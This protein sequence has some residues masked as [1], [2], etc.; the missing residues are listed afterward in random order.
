M[1]I[2][3]KIIP[4]KGVELDNHELNVD[5]M[6]ATYIKNLVHDLNDNNRISRDEGSNAYVWTP[7]ELTERYCNLEL[8]AGTNYVVGFHYFKEANQGFVFAYNNNNNHF[9]YR[10]K[11]NTG[12][13]EMIVIDPCFNFQ[14][15]PKYF[16]G[17]GR[18]AAQTICRLNKANGQTENVIYLEFTENF[19]D[20]RFLC[21]E[22]V[23]ATHGFN[24]TDF[25]YFNTSD[26]NCNRCTWFNLGVPAPFGCIGVTPVARDTSD[27][28][29]RTRPNVMNY[30]GW[31]FRVQIIDQWNRESEYDIISDTYFTQIG[32]SCLANSSGLPRCVRLRFPAGC[33]LVNQIVL[34][35]RNCAGKT[36]GFST[37]SD[38]YKFTTVNKYNDC[39]NA[40]WWERSINNPWLVEYDAQILLGKTPEEAEAIAYGKGL[41]RYWAIDNTFEYTFCNDKECTPIDVDKTNRVENPLARRSSS[42]FPLNRSIALARNTKGFDPMDCNELN[43]IE[44][45][46]VPPSGESCSRVQLKKVEIW[47]IFYSPNNDR[48][49]R[50]RT[51]DGNTVFGFADCSNNNPINFDQIL[52]KDQEGIIG[53][54]A[55]TDYYCISKQYRYDTVLDTLEYTGIN[56]TTP[57]GGID[58]PRYIPVQ[59]WEFNVLPGKYRFHIASHKS[60]PSDYKGTSTYFI[61]RTN[62]TSVGGLVAGEERELV[63]DVCTADYLL[64]NTPVMIWDLTHVGKNC[65]TSSE[66]ASAVAGYMYEDELQKNPID[67]AVV[68]TN[69]DG[70]VNKCSFT[71]HYG[72]YFATRNGRVLRATIRGYKNCAS[73]QEL[74]VGRSTLDTV[75]NWFKFDKLYAYHNTDA[76]PINDRMIVKGKLTLCGNPSIGLPGVLV[77]VTRAGFAVTDANGEYRI[78]MHDIG[79]SAARTESLIISQRGSCQI[80]ACQDECSFCFANVAVNRV[81]CVI[82]VERYLNLP[83]IVGRINAANS[84]GPKMGGR[85]RGGW[86]LYDWLGRRSFVQSS[87]KHYFNIPGIQETQV[88]SFSKIFFDLNG[89]RFPSWVTKI[90]PAI[91]EN[92]NWDDDI[93]WV[94]ERVQFVDNTGK[95]NTAAPTQIRL[96]YESLNEYNKQNDYSTNTGWQFLTEQQNSIQGDL[97]EFLANADGSIFNTRITALAKYNKEGK[98]IQVDYTDELKD[99]K[100]GT[101]VKLIRPKQCETQQWFYELCFPIR[102]LNGQAVIQSGELNYFDS[103]LLTRQIPVPTEVKTTSTDENGDEI[104]T[105]TTENQITAYPFFFEHHSPSDTWGDHCANRG[106]VGVI[107]EQEKQRCVKTGIDVSNALVNDGL[108]NGLH[109]FEEKDTTILDEQEWG[110][111]SICL[112]EQNIIL[113]ICEFTNCLIT[114]NDNR[115]TTDDQGNV[116]APSGENRFGR[117]EK[118]IGNDFGCQLDDINTIQVKDGLVMFLDSSKC[119]LVKHNY[120]EAEDVSV[121]TNNRGGYKSWL[122]AMIKFVIDNN[123]NP[124]NQK[125]YWH[126]AINPKNNKYTLTLATLGQASNKY[127][128]QDREPVIGVNDTIA[129]DIYSGALK[130][131]LSYT[132]EY[133]GAMSGDKNDSQ[134]ISFRFGE[135]WRHNKLNNPANLYNRFYGVDV[136]KVMEVVYN[137]DNV[138]VKKYMWNEVYCP[139][140]LFYADRIITESG[141]ISRIMPKWWERRDKF[142]C[143]DF[144]C[145]SNTQ[146]DINIPKETGANALLDGDMLYGRWMRV[147]YVGIAAAKNKYCELTAF[148]GFMYG[149]EKSGK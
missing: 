48:I 52:P 21:V 28:V 134:L 35:F 55:G 126:A 19:N 25:P 51:K 43:K 33:P 53:H 137:I 89:A 9:I 109:Y 30:R 120:N 93:T 110:G 73:N 97:I 147:R 77:H 122:S 3:Q 64:K 146:A 128:N 8:P 117:P 96:Y 82:G 63:I 70:D 34:S 144:K 100:D 66:A 60:T 2:P 111:I 86:F 94:I 149:G 130:T 74:A 139:Q 50:I 113:V 57:S 106:R 72:F 36:K 5:E 4:Y 49:T 125:M 42:L 38:W 54:M 78:I 20:Q 69:H 148:I 127:I 124:E 98:Y 61:G 12:D 112:P 135:A 13:C 103:Y 101:L 68:T 71:D 47:G 6:C 26:P 115:V 81:A 37:V 56:Y 27:P 44:F 133:Y 46:V 143:A 14:L 79:N 119:A 75:E 131:F 32:N 129:V 31:Q 40:N 80:L 84:K 23:I 105:S 10:I 99:L 102:I 45:S 24:G 22:D 58:N 121:G 18:C 59:K 116:V 76:Y 65:T 95:T 138:K 107:N 136:E 114:Y 104:E 85:Y 140:H 15:D 39:E 123:S 108:L 62:L 17:K 142:F 67:M 91:T 41:M 92:L 145:A 7:L 83:P 87:E 88:Y 16:I 29:E 118:K 141:Q 132:P 90:T 11:G 1:A